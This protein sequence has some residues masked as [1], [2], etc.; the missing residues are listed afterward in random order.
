MLMQQ[1]DKFTPKKI[2][3][4]LIHAFIV[5]VLCGATIGI[6]RSI[7]TME[8]TLIIHA[9]GAPIFAAS[10]SL[11]YYKKFNYSSPVQTAFIFLFFIIAM[12]AGVVAPVF[13]KSYEMFKSVLGTWIP[14][15]LIFLSTYVTGL[16]LKK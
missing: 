12:D 9:I 8:L 14:F 3:I 16:I 10:I 7:T 5:W 1:T 13:E 15:A 6:G 4:V 11:I 2:I